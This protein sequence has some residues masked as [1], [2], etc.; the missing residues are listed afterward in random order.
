LFAFARV[1][2]AQTLVCLFNFT[3]VPQSISEDHLRAAGVV[4]FHDQLSGAPAIRANGTVHLPAYGR[5]WLV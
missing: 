4:A 1:G 5:L 3:E 2:D